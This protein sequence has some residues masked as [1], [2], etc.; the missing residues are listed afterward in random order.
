MKKFLCITLMMFIT[1]ASAWAYEPISF[2][3]VQKAE[4]LSAAEL[5]TNSKT[6]V[7]TAFNSARDVIQMSDDN[8]LITKGIHTYKDGQC[9]CSL[10]FTLKIESREGRYKWTMNQ[11]GLTVKWMTNPREFDFG[12]LTDS[13]TCDLHKGFF[14]AIKV[15]N[16]W[17]GAKD[18]AIRFQ[19]WLSEDLAKSM[20]KKTIE[21]EW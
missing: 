4:G 11:I 2:S 8:I 20:I 16:I 21:E 13:E 9:Q 5:F 15:N 14:G 1:L 17:N 7:A 6:W 19:K 12:I 3:G 18:E 10:S